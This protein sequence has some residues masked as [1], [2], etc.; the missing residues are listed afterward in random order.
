MTGGVILS[1]RVG[2]QIHHHFVFTRRIGSI[3]PVPGAA[4]D[5]ALFFQVGDGHIDGL[6]GD[7]APPGNSRLRGEA[8]TTGVGELS[9]GDQNELAG[10]RQF[11][12]ESPF[13]GLDAHHLAHPTLKLSPLSFHS[14]VPLH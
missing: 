5:E 11:L 6:A 3:H 8:F 10:V 14:R 7:A 9:E 4:L 1:H 2:G 13:N 12:L